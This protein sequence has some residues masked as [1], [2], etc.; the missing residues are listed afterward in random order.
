[1]EIKEFQKK[2]IEYVRKWD[3]KRGKISD[4]KTTF[5][6]LVEEV[7]ELARQYV[8]KEIRKDQYDEKEI[9]DAIFD[10]LVQLIRLA[11]LRNIDMEKLVLDSMKE[12]EKRLGK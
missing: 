2:I 12:N 7:G 3:E 11:D 9:E 4:E 8:N 5:A 6:H 10:I 1:M